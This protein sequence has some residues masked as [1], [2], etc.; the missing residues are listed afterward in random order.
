MARTAS[1]IYVPLDVTFFD[2]ER[3]LTAGEA[4]GWLYLAMCAK[5]KAID[6][7]GVLTELQVAR[8]GVTGW[9][10]R[11]GRLIESGLVEEA[12]GTHYGITGW[13]KWN[14][15]AASRADRRQRDRD[16][17]KGTA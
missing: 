4:A 8:L 14:E 11:L 17:K 6:S 16:R 1:R 15:S 10:R 7:D 5:A 3:I 13:L 9:R 12:M 2:D